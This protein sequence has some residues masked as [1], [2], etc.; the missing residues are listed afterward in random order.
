MTVEGGGREQGRRGKGG[1]RS[2][3]NHGTMIEILARERTRSSLVSRA[4]KGAN[5]QRKALDRFIDFH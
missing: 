5:M 3:G 4:I 2:D 1:D